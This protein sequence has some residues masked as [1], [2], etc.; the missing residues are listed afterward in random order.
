MTREELT[1]EFLSSTE[2]NF[3]LQLPTSYGKSK[4]ALQKVNQ[5]YKENSNILIVIPRLVLINNWKEE[6]LKWKYDKFLPNITFTTYVS[7]HKHC[8]KIWDVVIFDEGHHL[9]ERC[10]EIMLGLKSR[11]LIVLSATINKDLLL[12]FTRTFHPKVFNIKVKDAIES[13]VLPDP[14]IILIPLTLDTRVNNYMIEKN[15]KTK[16]A[17]SFTV[18]DY[19]LKWKYRTFKGPLRIKCTQ[20]QYYNDMT[21]L[22]E[23][24]KER[25]KHNAIMKNMWLHK[26]GE[27]LKW[28]AL[29]KEQII[30]DLLK[31]LKNY[32]TLVYCPSIEDSLKV[33][34]PCINSKIGIESLTLFNE[35][36][37]KHIAAVGMLDEGANLV[38]CKVGIFKMIN[39]SDRLTVQRIG[40]LMRHKSPV[41]IFPYFVD[42]REQEI[43]NEITKDYNPELITVLSKSGINTIKKH[44]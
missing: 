38:E 28:L 23:W 44:L 14:K 27:R 4:L 42:T 36:K 9:S 40:R 10:R 18:I 24:Y 21:G 7:L 29:Q 5:W 20:R 37:I 30:K 1:Q 41:L 33:G 22:I 13:S 43:V 17:S 35:K 12:Y 11:H 2:K 16:K 6:V 31:E 25:G 39:S 8:N 19:A 15:N 34:S 26:A 3:I 32:R